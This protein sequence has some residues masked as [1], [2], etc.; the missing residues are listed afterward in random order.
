MSFE[1][2]DEE[3]SGCRPVVIDTKTSK[4]L[5]PEHP[6]MQ[7]VNSVW[8]QTT[9]AEREAF[10]RVTCQNSRD[11]SDISLIQ[12]ISATIQASL[13]ALAQKMN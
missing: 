9:R 10:H 5:P 7:S 11:A 4:A 1:Q 3:C 6:I 2:Y 13:E 12:K 8:A